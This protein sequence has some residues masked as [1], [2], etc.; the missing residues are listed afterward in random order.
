MATSNMLKVAIQPTA[1]PIDMA[2][3]AALAGRVQTPG[4]GRVGGRALSDQHDGA[5]VRLVPASRRPLRRT[6]FRWAGGTGHGMIPGC[7]L[8]DLPVLVS[9]GV[10]FFIGSVLEGEQGVVG[11]RHGME[12]LVELALSCS[13]LS[14]LGVLDNEDHCEGKGAHRGLE[15]GFPPGGESR[16]GAGDYPC[17]G[18]A[19]AE[20]RSRR[21]GCMPVY[22][23]QPP[24]GDRTLGRRP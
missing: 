6:S 11:T 19:D 22:L 3:S 18:R 5:E 24:A 23:G 14:R 15:D 13:L 12:D 4:R 21:P 16:G 10:Q 20:C 7:G 2:I 17:C 8:A 1:V 9:C